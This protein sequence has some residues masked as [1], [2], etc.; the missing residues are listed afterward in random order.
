VLLGRQQRF[1]A[2]SPVGAYWLARCE[3][4]EVVAR[5]GDRGTV[6]DVVFR[7][8]LGPPAFLIVRDGR[9]LGKRRAIAV[10]EVVE[11]D[12]WARAVRLRGSIRACAR[13]TR[14]HAEARALT[15]GP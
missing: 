4:F 15:A 14:R 11:V 2:D 8:P 12:P 1:G 7:T 3:G 5:D 10:D 9:F 13:R 6:E